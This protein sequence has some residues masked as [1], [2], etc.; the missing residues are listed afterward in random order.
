MATINA[1]AGFSLMETAVGN[2]VS[3]V[4]GACGGGLS[5]ATCH[6][7]IDP[8]FIERLEP[9]RTD[10]LEL[11]EVLQERTDCSRLSCQVTVTASLDGMVVHLPGQQGY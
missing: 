9:P 2:G 7:H 8:E 11:L 1:L 3:G 10:E 4:E 5:C 6:V